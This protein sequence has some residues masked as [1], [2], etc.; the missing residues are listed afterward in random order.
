MDYCSLIKTVNQEDIDYEQFANLVKGGDLVKF[1]NE[2]SISVASLYKSEQLGF[3]I[4][5]GAMNYL[6][7]FMT[8][9][10]FLRF[11]GD[12]IPSPAID[13]YEAFDAGE[14]HHRGDPDEVCPIE[15]YTNKLVEEILSNANS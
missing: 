9:D 7:G 15:K 5:D 3:D 13:V 12:F 4:C 8:D 10:I 11:S 6:F 1:V 14:Y 2:F